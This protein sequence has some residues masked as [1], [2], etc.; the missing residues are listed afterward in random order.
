M[1]DPLT[2]T[3]A[4]LALGVSAWSAFNSHQALRV[5][6]D[7]HVAKRAERDARPELSLDVRVANHAPDED[8][9]FR[10]A[11]SSAYFNLAVTVGNRGNRTAGR[12]QIDV[13]VPR[14]IDSQTLLWMGDDRG[15]RFGHASA[16]PF[17]HLPTFDGRSFDTQRLRHTIDAVPLIGET[18]SFRAC[19]PLDQR[20][21]SWPVRVV[22]RT[23]GSEVEELIRIDVMRTLDT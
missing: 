10:L 12:T 6:R 5:T 18:L 11:A 1:A 21:G 19:L 2:L 13:W 17:V 8:G 15:E 3:V 7:E 14:H 22:A 16:D 23:D 4:S 20:L 9:V